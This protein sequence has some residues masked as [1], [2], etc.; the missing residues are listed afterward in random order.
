M[1]AAKLLRESPAKV[2][3]LLAAIRQNT[4]RTHPGYVTVV[5]FRTS[6]QA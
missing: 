5:A 3:A 1:S 2:D 6:C 4:I